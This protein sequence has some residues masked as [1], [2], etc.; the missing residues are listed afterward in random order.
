MDCSP[1]GFFVHGISQARILEWVAISFSRGS[2]QPRNQISVSCIGRQI[3]YPCASR[4]AHTAFRAALWGPSC[5]KLCLRDCMDIKNQGFNPRANMG[6]NTQTPSAILISTSHK[7][8]KSIFFLVF[9][10]SF[11]FFSFEL[12]F[13]LKIFLIFHLLY[14][15]LMY[16]GLDYISWVHHVALIWRVRNS[17]LF[18]FLFHWFLET[19]NVTISHFSNFFVV[20]LAF[21]CPVFLK[22]LFILYWSTAN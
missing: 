8:L 14:L 1:P 16:E 19:L 10:I 17:L 21:F 12:S 7:E 15:F 22:K 3:L 6:L 20:T 4:K 13:V 9:W 11:P 2:S 5:L 18:Q